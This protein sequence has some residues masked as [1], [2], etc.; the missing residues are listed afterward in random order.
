MATYEIINP[1]DKV[2]I[3]GDD[4]EVLA[5]ALCFIGNG[6]YALCNQDGDQVVPIFL[7]GGHDEWF[8]EQFGVD[9][10]TSIDRV[11]DTKPEAL[12]E[13]LESCFIGD[14]SDLAS[15]QKGLDLI[16]DADKREQWR[17]HWKEERRSS[18]NDIC[19]RAW[20]YADQVR[21]L[22]KTRTAERDALA[23]N[24]AQL[25]RGLQ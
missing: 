7:F 1:S 3:T 21:N 16:E 22:A 13:A 9:L 15:Y 17:E 23:S 24:P 4:M 20:T 25:G 2:L 19:G 5:V 18:L 10:S 11:T 6:K 14:F 8:T 12:I